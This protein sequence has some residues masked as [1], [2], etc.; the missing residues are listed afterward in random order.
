MERAVARS[1]CFAKFLIERDYLSASMT[2][3]GSGFMPPS[4]IAEARQHLANINHLMAEMET[5]TPPSQS[6]KLNQTPPHQAII[7]GRVATDS[8]LS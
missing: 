5:Y 4:V 2:R 8:R 3:L 6:A 7:D 1:M